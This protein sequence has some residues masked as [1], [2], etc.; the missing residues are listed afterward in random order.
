MHNMDGFYVSKLK[1]LKAGE[2]VMGESVDEEPA[3][4]QGG[5]AAKSAAKKP[6]H[7]GAAEPA[8][9]WCLC[10]RRGRPYRRCCRR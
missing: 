8:L 5:K 6:K 9:A 4:E 3:P 7:K 2:K 1:V 10:R